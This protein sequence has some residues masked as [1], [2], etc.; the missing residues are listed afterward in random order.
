MVGPMADFSD[1]LSGGRRVAVRMVANEEHYERVVE[2]VR[3]AET[4]VWIATAN[5]KEML[6]EGPWPRRR[7]RSVLTDLAELSR[8]GVE[9]RLMHAAHP[10]RPFRRSFDRL[11]A[12]VAGG[13]E[14]RLCPRLHFKAVIVDGAFLY[15]GSANWTGAG[16]GAKGEHKRNFELGFVT[17]DCG[18]LDEVQATY[19]SLWRGEPCAS[20]RLRETC[21]MP[22]DVVTELAG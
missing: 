3:R 11:E 13:L 17:A 8:R 21:E 12:L 1:L 20:C 18:L 5:L 16:L 10:S 6:V 9:L 2:A 4:S 7:Y 22:L 15:L 14:M 19:E